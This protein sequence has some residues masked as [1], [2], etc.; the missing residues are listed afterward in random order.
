MGYF[1]QFN[2]VVLDIIIYLNIKLVKENCDFSKDLH[3]I[4]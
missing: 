1:L 4:Y 2:G 3:L